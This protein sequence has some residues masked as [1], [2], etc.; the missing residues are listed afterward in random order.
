M[1]SGRGAPEDPWLGIAAALGAGALGIGVVVWGIGQMAAITLGDGPLASGASRMPGVLARLPG[2][3][4]DPAAAWPPADRARLPGPVGFYAV[5][6]VVLGVLAATIVLGTR[7]ARSVNQRSARSGAR[8]ARAGDLRALVV[9][10][11][12]SGRLTLGRLGRR[13][14]ATESRASTI[15][16]G[17]SQSGKTAGLAIPAILEAAGPVL[18]VSVK[19][20]LLDHTLAARRVRGPVC[21]YD[22][23]G[24]AHLDS[25]E[26]VGWDPVR[27]CVE[28]ADARRMAHNLT[29][30]HGSAGGRDAE[31]W[32]QMAAKLLA[33]LLVAAAGKIDGSMRDV[34]AWVDSGEQAA[35]S[36]LLLDLGEPDAHA[37]FLATCRREERTLSSVYATA[38]AALS[39]FAD[40]SVLASTDVHGIEP[41]DLLGGAG[42]LYVIAPAKD[43]ERLAP[44]F[45]GLVE[46]VVDAA[47]ARAAAGR[48]CDPA[49][50][51]V[52]DEAANT[53]P[54][55]TLP[56]I[57][58]TA[59]G[60]GIQVV[61]VFQD[62][63]QARSRYGEAADTI[64]ANHR[65]KLF[66]SGISDGRTL[67]YLGRA[68][69]EEEV[70]QESRTRGEG[71]GNSRTR[72][73]R[74]RRL[75]P[76]DAVRGV[77]PGQAILV[78]GHL[79][80]A[81][82]RLRPWYRERVLRRLA[83]HGEDA[84]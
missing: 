73:T 37:A 51:V 58:A 35:V 53:A 12:Q 50:L 15:V 4:A 21:I 77:A 54:I 23:T 40:P 22:P 41:E 61:T 80:P 26:V 63:A 45:A 70:A 65:A 47:Y 11:P 7:I 69:G 76:A 42:T 64:L 10:R 20:D 6:A 34:V 2:T 52:L 46:H 71:G 18:A 78:Y 79:P 43:Q 48:P 30:A 82:L 83:A 32:L 3:L 49:L 57:A 9:R 81:R 62:L 16:I 33:P 39:P 72:S 28:W 24:A 75:A 19:R 74:S 25:P 84:R 68:L 13:L 67:D 1:A 56:Q 59:A 44:L 36:G 55:R 60:Q 14:V 29:S 31:F 27:A 8:W 38:E 5:A 66:L 17:P